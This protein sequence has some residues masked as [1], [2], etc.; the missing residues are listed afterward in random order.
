MEPI[1]A[2]GL[3]LVTGASGYIAGFTIKQLIAEGWAVRGTIRDLGKADGL[4]SLLS[5]PELDLVAAD[6]GADA[7]WADAVRGV[8]H[9]L[10]IASPIPEREPKHDDELVIPARDG[11]LRVLRAARDA[12]VKR[13]VMTSSTAAICYGMDGD[14]RTFTEADW[15]NPDHPDT[16]A[17]VR[18]KVIAERAARAFMATEGGAPEYCTINPGAV[19]GPVLGKDFS[20]SLE[21]V[22]KLLG[23]ELPGCPRLGFPLV[24]VRDIADI[25]IRAMVA[26]AMNGE[27]FLAAGKFLWMKDIAEIL[28]IRLGAQARKVPTR[29]LPDFLVKLSALIDPTVRMVIPELGKQR[30]CDA[31]HAAAVLGW[32]PRPIEETI[33]ECAQSLIAAGLVKVR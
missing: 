1:V 15:T 9:V 13:L 24:D 11:A 30:I 3:V 8:D 6:L 17:Y 28:K 5:A 33:T 2:K 18:S 23:G 27:R 22:R 16:Y 29:A 12:G 32:R 19:L 4:R 7:G 26:P 20:T 14:S 10:H 31:S 21:V 25:H